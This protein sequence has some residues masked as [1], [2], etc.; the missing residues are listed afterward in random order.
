MVTFCESVST[1]CRFS[2]DE[3]HYEPASPPLSPS[4][5]LSPTVRA[6]TRS[7]SIADPRPVTEGDLRAFRNVVQRSVSCSHMYTKRR[8]LQRSSRSIAPGHRVLLRCHDQAQ[9]ERTKETVLRLVETVQKNPNDSTSP[10]VILAK[11]TLR[12]RRMLERAKQVD[13]DDPSMVIEQ[14]LLEMPG[15]TQVVG[16]HPSASHETP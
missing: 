11:K 1:C 5:S 8:T 13:L 15:Q 6:R 9:C 7:E 14:L 4:P 3:P 16:C 12:Y 10:S 2:L